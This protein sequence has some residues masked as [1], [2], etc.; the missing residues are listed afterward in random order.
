VTALAPLV[1]AA[2][3]YVAAARR[4]RGWP[5]WR[6]SAW[7]AGLAVLALCLAGLD[8]QADRRLSAHMLQ[9]AGLTLL[10]PP[11]L[12]LAA[13][14]RLALRAASGSTRRALAAALGGRALRTLCHPLAAWTLF[15]ATLL[16]THLTGVYELALRS[17]LVH[18]L[19]HAAYFWTAVLFWLPLAGAT[20]VP[21]RLG[22]L[23]ALAYLMTAMP[24]MVALGIWLGGATLRYPAYAGPGALADQ[25]AAAAIMLG[26]GALA[27]LAAVLALVWPALLREER[28]QR[29]REAV[30]A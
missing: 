29:A 24:V 7:L 12:L 6:S 5:R 10:A 26:S 28:R 19:E 22:P 21:Y 18:A 9:H 4:A 11:L 25:H 17:P 1:A 13:P 20:P 30:T 27:M 8:D 3:A 2:L 14:A 23:G 15:C 16:A